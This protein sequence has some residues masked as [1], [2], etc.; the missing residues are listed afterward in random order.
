MTPTSENSIQE[1]F[2]LLDQQPSRSNPTTVGGSFLFEAVLLCTEKA[3]QASQLCAH[4]RH[5][6]QGSRW[7]RLLDG[8]LGRVVAEPGGSPCGVVWVVTAALTGVS[9][10]SAPSTLCTQLSDFAGRARSDDQPLA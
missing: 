9:F 10:L 2:S 7:G 6:S 3:L 5:R 4:K 1:D 8:G